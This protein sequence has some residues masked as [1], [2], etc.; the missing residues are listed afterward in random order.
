[1][2]FLAALVGKVL[3]REKVFVQLFQSSSVCFHKVPAIYSKCS[4]PAFL[5]VSS[6]S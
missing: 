2:V 3:P 6:L 1:M 4:S 5:F